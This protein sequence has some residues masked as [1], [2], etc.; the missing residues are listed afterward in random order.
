MVDF[1]IGA[2]VVDRPTEFNCLETG[3]CFVEPEVVEGGTP[4]HRGIWI[5]N[6]GFSA[7]RME[8]CGTGATVRLPATRRVYRVRMTVECTIREEGVE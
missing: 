5:K 6:G 3:E 1:Q 8:S 2:I 7:R 4:K